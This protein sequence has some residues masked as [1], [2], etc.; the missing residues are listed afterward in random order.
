[1]RFQQQCEHSECGLACAAMIIDFFAKKTK[2]TYLREKY[3]VPNGGYNLLQLKT[4]LSENGV[5]SRAVKTDGLDVETLPVPFIAFWKKRHFIIVEKITREKVVI[6][7]PS[8]GRKTIGRQEFQSNYSQ[9]ALYVLNGR[10]RKIQIP[11]LHY[12]IKNN[13]R[14]N[15]GLLFATLL[16]SMIVQ[17]LS[18]AIPYITQQVID[19]FEGT[20]S[21]NPRVIVLSV[22]LVFIC[23]FFSNFVR[24]RVI[25]IMQTSFD[26]GFLGDTIERLLHLPYSYFVNRSK[27][28]IIYRINSNSYIR[29]I[30]V[31]QMMELAI[32]LFFFFIYLFAMIL[33]SPKLSLVTLI[34][35]GILCI[36]SFANA[37]VN[38]KIQQNEIVVVTKS[39]DLVNELINNVFTIKST[40]SQ[41]N[42]FNKWKEN[43]DKQVEY[44]KSR[45]NCNSVFSNLSQS[46]YSFYPLLIILVGYFLVSKEEVTLGGIIAF[47]TIGQSFIRPILTIM[48]SYAQLLMVKLYI[49]RLV[50]IL[51]TPD[52]ASFTGDKKI[53]NYSGEIE[54][55]NISYKYSSF[56]PFAVSDISLRIKSGQKIAIVGESGSGKSTLLKVMSGLYQP[57]SGTILYDKKDIRDLDIYNMREKIGIVL[58][59]SMLFN[60]S[61]RD[62][63]CMGRDY[64]DEKISYSIKASKLDEL[65]YSF[66]LGLDT[67]ISEGGQNLSGG[68]RQRVAIART[69]VSD[70]K[71]I[72]L[73]EPTSA[74]DNESEKI[75][76]ENLIKMNIT[77]VVAAHRLSTI[78]KFDKI[79]VMDKGRIVEIGRHDEL[80]KQNGYYARL[81]NAN[82]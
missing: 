18:L 9:I 5:D 42:I 15:K 41:K 54:L 64:T 40:N 61:F 11:R 20:D 19:S 62:N 68:Q 67:M 17:V 32:D 43:F 49:D 22:F 8:N 53:D 46:I 30:L 26:K 14:R 10:H 12:V 25:T 66:P 6:I 39:Q 75:V 73:D 76:M 79:I 59:E 47:C 50:D 3:G 74:L 45:A 21:F 60:G 69:I 71:A 81:Y 77:M 44:E 72:F 23:Y 34:I 48:N 28:E 1:M 65:V 24:T 52:E 16:I 2:L 7:D 82:G 78:E 38:Y 27:G 56:S 58:Q 33:Y 55:N 4:V 13:I 29:Q 36:S 63:I 57:T 31:D 37:K 80:L 51:D 35:A 70:P